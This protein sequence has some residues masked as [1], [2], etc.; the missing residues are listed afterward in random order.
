MVASHIRRTWEDLEVDP[1]NAKLWTQHARA[2]AALEHN[3]GSPLLKQ[4]TIRRRLELET[5][6]SEPSQLPKPEPDHSAE[7]GPNG[8]V[9]NSDGGTKSL[10]QSKPFL[11]LCSVHG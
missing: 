5:A 7:S 10:Q 2:N 6:S 9:T 1:E 4:A 8:V 11:L 3:D